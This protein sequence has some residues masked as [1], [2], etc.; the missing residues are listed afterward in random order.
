MLG[1]AEWL[2]PHER[3]GCLLQSACLCPCEHFAHGWGGFETP[4][5]ITYHPFFFS[6]L[7]NQ[8][9]KKI[10]HTFSLIHLYYQTDK[11]GQILQ[12][13]RS[14]VLTCGKT[15]R[16]Y[17]KA[18][19]LKMDFLVDEVSLTWLGLHWLLLNYLYWKFSSNLN[20][21]AFRFKNCLVSLHF[22][23]SPASKNQ[24]AKIDD[25]WGVK[26]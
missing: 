1:M 19:R 5:R 2:V 15:A 6:F 20:F 23:Y 21:L 14:L 10:V 13:Y 11:D 25:C 12:C 16:F 9:K 8:T 24:S 7:P 26:Y 17:Q 22:K 18:I 4:K 3:N